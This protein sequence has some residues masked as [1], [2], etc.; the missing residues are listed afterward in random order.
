MEQGS[1]S[2]A[3][4]D[5]GIA[6]GSVRSP[7]CPTCRS[8]RKRERGRT[9]MRSW[10]DANRERVQSADRIRYASDPEPRR[11]AH[12]QWKARN[13]G[14]SQRYYQEHRERILASNKAWRDANPD[15]MAALKSAWL[16]TNREHRQSWVRAYSATNHD[17]M[18]AWRRAYAERNR[19]RLREQ[20]QKWR[21]ANP[22]K[23]K[24]ANR[25][26]YALVKG[27]TA[28][29]IDYLTVFEDDAWTCRLCGTPVDP[30]SPWPEPS[31]PSVDHIVPFARGGAHVR[32]NVQTAHLVCNMRKNSDPSRR[33]DPPR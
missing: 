5:C 8:V 18:L 15:R 33:I 12:A 4:M 1:P 11:A 2:S 22:Y 24:A 32:S 16:S 7:R 25:K 17:Q 30:C 10:R 14:H 27:V 31:S 21:A 23:T 9:R 19:D 13:P 28:E 29:N 3:C 6:T 26:R 20:D